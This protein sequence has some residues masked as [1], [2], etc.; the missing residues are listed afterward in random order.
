MPLISV[1]CLGFFFFFLFSFFTFIKFITDHFPFETLYYRATLDSQKKEKK[2]G[3]K[4]NKKIRSS[5][6]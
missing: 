1:M 5:S 3:K 4:K 6:Y 2:R